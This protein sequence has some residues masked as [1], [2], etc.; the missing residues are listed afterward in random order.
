LIPLKKYIYSF[1]AIFLT[2]YLLAFATGNSHI[3]K[4]ISS[5]YLV[6]EAKPTI[7]DY[8]LFE[9]RTIKTGEYQPWKI[10]TK[11]KNKELLLKI[12]NLDPIAFLVVK[13]NQIVYENYWYDYNESS[14]TNSFSI[15][16]TFIGLLIGIAIDEGKIKNV[17]DPVYLYLP[18]YKNNPEL[19]IKHLLTMSSGIN[20]D[21]N[22]K[23][24]F[25]HMAKAY[26]GTD[27][28]RLNDFYS[29]TKTPGEHW[30]YLGGN[31]IIL[32]LIIEKVTG[33]SV[34][35]YMSKKV[36]KPIGAK[37]PGLWSLDKKNGREKAYCCFYSNARDFARIG[38]LYLN[39]GKWGNTQIVSEKYIQKS[40]A[41]AFDLKDKNNNIVDY[42]G[43]QIWISKYKDLNIFYARGIQGQY[44]IIIPEKE[45]V[46][47]RLGYER[48]KNH[49]KDL[50]TYI[51]FALEQ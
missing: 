28:K 23:N 47:V 31:T 29:V 32:S 48:N 17:D 38:Q 37:N 43:Y 25:G 35:D 34:S 4:A 45:I 11:S 22:Y 42:Y 6:G 14:L 21:E 5:T 44:I 12:E 19:T 9:N 27:I 18:Q 41:P 3:F 51:N 2:L 8:P 7:N 46:I 15:A 13:G 39:K 20:F 24:P 50:Y 40:T 10:N 16:K 36:W 49:H 26:Y 1:L 30:K 33:K